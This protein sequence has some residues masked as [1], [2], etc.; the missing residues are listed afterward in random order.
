MAEDFYVDPIECMGCGAPPIAAPDLM[1]F[2]TS[3]DGY[4]Q[5]SFLRQPSN[6]E[7]EDQAC[8]GV[9][10]SCCGAADYR[11]KDRRIIERIAILNANKGH[12]PD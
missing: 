7:E 3:E 1:K 9:W 4:W 11:G 2:A 6:R 10:A 8:R 5:C 12:F